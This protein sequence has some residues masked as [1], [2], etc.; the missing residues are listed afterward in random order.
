MSDESELI[1]S[2][3][4]VIGNMLEAYNKGKEIDAQIIAL[5]HNY[6]I[7]KRQLKL[8]KQ[9]L[10]YQHQETVK[11]IEASEKMYFA[12]IEQHRPEIE[13]NRHLQDNLVEEAKT[14]LDYAITQQMP[15]EF[16]EMAIAFHDRNWNTIM[17]LKN[18]NQFFLLE[19][20]I[21]KSINKL[22]SNNNNQI[23]E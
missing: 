13:H 7:E 3:G 5:N 9:A 12:K 16:F 8:A 1:L 11:R 18:I 23:E 20:P 2:I 14:F 17:S 6:N 4:S 21:E 22:L 19:N 10:E 15:R